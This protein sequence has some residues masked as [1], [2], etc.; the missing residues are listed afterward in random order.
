MCSE[1][2]TECESKCALIL[3]MNVKL[4]LHCIWNWMSR[5]MCTEFENEYEIK[6][7]LN[8]KLNVKLNV[9]WIWSWMWN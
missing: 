4:N 6:C 2:E 3:K 1:F 8:L 7:A 5:K 9:H